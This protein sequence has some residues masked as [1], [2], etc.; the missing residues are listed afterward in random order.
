MPLRFFRRGRRGKEI[1]EGLSAH[2]GLGGRP[3]MGRGCSPA[4]A[5]AQARR[6]FGNAGLVKEVTR[7]SWG[8]PWLER[9]WRDTRYGAR[10]LRKNPGFTI[11]AVLSLAFGIGAAIAVFS[12]AD[13]VLLRPLPYSNPK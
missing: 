4:D 5:E 6:S 8:Y 13:T 12:I 11:A 7:T 2:P 9:L 3:L 10:V 1:E